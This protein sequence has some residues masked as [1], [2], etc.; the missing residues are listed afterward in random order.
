MIVLKII[1]RILLTGLIPIVPFTMLALY[2]TVL[3][4]GLISLVTWSRDC[5]SEI[6]NDCIM[7][8]IVVVTA[9]FGWLMGCVSFYSGICKIKW[10]RI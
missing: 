1:G 7:I 10:L 4:A 8:P 3:L 5:G 2:A 6:L 9:V